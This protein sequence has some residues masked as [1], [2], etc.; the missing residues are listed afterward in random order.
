MKIWHHTD[1]SNP[2]P[3]NSNC[4][5]VFDMINSI[6][7]AIEINADMPIDYVR[8]SEFVKVNRNK[9]NPGFD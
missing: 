3:E 1:L 9:I 5:S 8:F 2:L 7:S 6:I 4:T